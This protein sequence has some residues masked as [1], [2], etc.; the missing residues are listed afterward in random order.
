MLRSVGFLQG[1][2]GKEGLSGLPADEG[3]K[4]RVISKPRVQSVYVYMMFIFTFLF[5]VLTLL[6]R[7]REARKDQGENQAPQYVIFHIIIIIISGRGR[8][9]SSSHNYWVLWYFFL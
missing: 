1:V 7:V 4:V 8:G 2:K 3:L 5:N 9:S 6:W